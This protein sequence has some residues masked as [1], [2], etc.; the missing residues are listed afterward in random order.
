MYWMLL[1]P[2]SPGQRSSPESLRDIYLAHFFST[3]YEAYIWCSTFPNANHISFFWRHS[4][5]QASQRNLSGQSCNQCFSVPFNI[6]PLQIL[7]GFQACSCCIA[8]SPAQ[9]RGHLW[10]PSGIYTWPTPFLH[11]MKPISDLFQMLILSFMLMT[12]FFNPVNSEAEAL[13][14]Q[15]DVN[16][17]ISWIQSCHSITPRCNSCQLAQETFLGQLPCF[18]ETA[19]Y[20][21]V[22]NFKQFVLVQLIHSKTVK[23]HLGLI[24]CRL[25]LAP[26]LSCIRFINRLICQSYTTAPSH[27]GSALGSDCI[28]CTSKV[29]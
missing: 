24:D 10:S 11:T 15:Q 20:L 19:K 17:I 28:A 14:L 29:C 6:L 12:L 3:Y 9:V 13:Q 5:V 7:T 2:P 4:F 18:P 22:T 27:V 1:H 25:Y 26:S 16:Q 21:G 23:C 8:Y